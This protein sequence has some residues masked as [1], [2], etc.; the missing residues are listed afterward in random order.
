MSDDIFE[1]ASKL[2]H[3]IK[4]QEAS[5][6]EMK[7]EYEELI[8]RIRKEN[9]TSVEYYIRPQKEPSRHAVSS[10]FKSNHP[11]F[12]AKAAHPSHAKAVAIMSKVCG[13]YDE[14]CKRMREQ[15]PEE[16]DK[17]AEITISDIK[18]NFSVEDIQKLEIDGAIVSDMV[19]SW[20]IVPK[21]LWQ[22]ERA[23]K[24]MA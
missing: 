15:Q 1:R 16:F 14:F 11:E 6:K 23:R 18:A 5:L 17:F 7:D 20:E 8:G 24:E 9:L 10:Y 21:P 22:V 2:M 12:Y 4:E 13:G 3:N 19:K